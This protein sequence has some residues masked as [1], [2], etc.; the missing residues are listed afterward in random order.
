MDEVSL[1]NE[2]I[3]GNATAQRKLFEKFAPKMLFI[4]KRYCKD[5]QDA[6]DVL[7]DAFIKVF[8][9][10]DK[11]KHEGSFEGWMRRIFVNS[12][13]DF[14]RKQKQLGD[15]AALDD[16]SYRLEDSSSHSGKTLEVEDLMQ[17]IAKLPKG[18]QVVFNL[19]AIEGYTHKEIADLLGISEETSKSQYFRARAYLKN[20]L[21][22][23]EIK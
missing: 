18:Y 7:Q 19:F 1:V 13:L 15:T 3:K 5:Q 16:V 17:M 14:L 21:E 12:C 23:T 11:Y 2:C 4:C 6:E 10:L 8:S 22:K 20:Y 9:S